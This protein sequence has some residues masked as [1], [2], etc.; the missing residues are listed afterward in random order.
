MA[1]G[2]Q[3]QLYHMGGSGDRP[4]VQAAWGSGRG[5]ETPAPL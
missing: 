3:A 2:L 1:L 5:A 4:P